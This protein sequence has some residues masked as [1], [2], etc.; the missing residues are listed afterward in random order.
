[1]TIILNNNQVKGDIK[2]TFELMKKLQKIMKIRAKVFNE[3][4]EGVLVDDTNFNGGSKLV[5][6][7]GMNTVSS[8]LIEI[9]DLL[10]E[11]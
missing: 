9:I 10:D 4:V 3:I 7:N 8:E 11:D 5:Y 6:N 2:N 1:M